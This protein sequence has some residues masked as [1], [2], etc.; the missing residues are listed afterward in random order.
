MK[1]RNLLVLGALLI[2]GSVWAE[3]QKPVLTDY[4]VETIEI[5]GKSEYYMYNAGAK[6]FWVGANAW[7]TQAS[8]G[9]TGWK[10][11]FSQYV[12]AEGEAWDGK[13]VLFEDYAKNSSWL[14]AWFVA[15]DHIM[16]T[17][18][19]NQADYLWCI[20][21]VGAAYRLSAS[22]LNPDATVAGN[23]VN[24]VGVDA[25]KQDTIVYSN[26]VEA[27]TS[28]IDWTFFSA[29]DYDAALAL[30]DDALLLGERIA[31]AEARVLMWL[32]RRMCSTTIRLLPKRWLL[33]LFL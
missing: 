23:A 2:S 33:L 10:V 22:E 11:R 30:Y 32:L 29:A 25:T 14:K 16:Y 7:G 18:Y 4:P 19:N 24:F 20:Q 28:Y 15:G 13:T 5:D 3:R 26:L 6:K 1:L 12:A 31:E 21:K 17:D 8:V 9:P 27:E